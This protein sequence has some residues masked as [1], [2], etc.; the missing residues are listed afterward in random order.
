MLKLILL[1]VRSSVMLKINMISDSLLPS[2]A[3]T[4]FDYLAVGIGHC[5]TWIV[6]NFGD[7]E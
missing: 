1:T 4:E 6:Y 2:Q 7:R 5:R 3:T